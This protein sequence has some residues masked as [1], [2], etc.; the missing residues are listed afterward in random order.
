MLLRVEDLKVEFDTLSG[1]AK[2]VDGASF[3]IEKGKTHVLVGESGCGKS[4]TSLALMGLLP[5]SARISGGKII[6]KGRDIAHLPRREYREYRG[7]EMGMIFQEPMT[8]L[9]PVVRVGYQI[10]E[11]I[12]QHA[13]RALVGEQKD[14]FKRAVELIDQMGI[15]EPDKTFFKYPH[16]LSGGMR[17]RIMIAISLA[18]RPSLLIADE[19]T[20]ALDVT[21]QEQILNLMKELQEKLGTAIL[22][23]TH[24]LGVVANMAHTM[25]VMYAGQIV[26]E[27]PVKEVFRNPCHPYTHAL[28]R[29]IPSLHSIPGTKLHTIPGFVPPATEYEKMPSPC[30][31]YERC[32]YKDDRCF[33]TGEVSGHN[34][35]CKRK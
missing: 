13:D 35:F 16:E 5:G 21:T 6:F 10:E 25:S 24:N 1:K 9:N 17:Q 3:S 20:T 28:F 34:S 18:C 19:P 33:K 2:A 4:V 31:F 26:E 7:A 29:A 15:H 12:R 22:L 32:E 11:A 30:R 23:I 14:P 8:A 27:G